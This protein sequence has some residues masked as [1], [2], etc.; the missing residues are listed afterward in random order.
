MSEPYVN[1][2]H[3]REVAGK[4]A[5]GPSPMHKV[6]EGLRAN[7]ALALRSKRSYTWDRLL[8]KYA[9]DIRRAGAVAWG[10]SKRPRR[11]WARRSN[12][13]KKAERRLSLD[14]LLSELKMKN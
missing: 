14:Q 13:Q 8:A 12:R 11:A 7:G 1:P 9:T 6:L 3:P 5:M 4:V 2:D 10:L